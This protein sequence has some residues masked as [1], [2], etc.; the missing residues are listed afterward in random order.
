MTGQRMFFKFA[1][2]LILMIGV[3]KQGTGLSMSSIQKYEY[4]ATESAPL[5]FP[6]QI[7]SGALLYH[8]GSGSLSVPNMTVIAGGWGEWRSSHVLDNDGYPLPNKLKITFYSFMENQ[9]YQAEFDLPFEK[10]ESLFKNKHYSYVDDKNITFDQFIIGTTPG[11]GVSVW[12]NAVERK[13]QIFY[14]QANKID[15]D[16]KWIIDNPEVNREGYIKEVV[17]YEQRTPEQLEI[18]NKNG[19]PFGKWEGYS[20]ARY[21]WKPILNGMNLRDNKIKYI[22][23]YSGEKDYLTIPMSDDYK[24]QPLS[25]PDEI[26]ITW[27]KTGY[28]I[29][30][31]SIDILFDEKE[32]FS[33]FE[34]ISQG[35]NPIEMEFRMEPE[36]N[37]DFTIWLRNDKNSI[38]LKKIRIKT[39]K[40]GGM[41]YENAEPMD[42]E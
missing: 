10:I 25:V 14:G 1:I 20:K 7:I 32:I 13:V 36:K 27:N 42:I 33:A 30:D 31:L 41:R 37:Y 40:P 8:D 26:N 15:G 9:F 12:V 16:W 17:E 21:V 38:E 19:I 23:Y 28:L 6:M 4:Q 35:N 18:Y 11:G 29:N 22:H 39:W 34:E 5:Y 24:D 2:M 3:I